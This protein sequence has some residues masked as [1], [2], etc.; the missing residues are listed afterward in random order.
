MD[1]LQEAHES[2]ENLRVADANRY[3]F[4]EVRSA[5]LKPTRSI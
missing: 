2:L 1:V 5:V 4:V 3:D